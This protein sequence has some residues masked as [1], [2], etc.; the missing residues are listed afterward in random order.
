MVIPFRPRAR[1]PH[2]AGAPHPVERSRRQLT[3]REISHR[4]RMLAHLARVEAARRHPS[5]ANALR[6][7]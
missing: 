3:A 2:D 6:S 5:A 7:A 1:S 4:E